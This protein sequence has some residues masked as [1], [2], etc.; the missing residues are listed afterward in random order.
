MPRTA[1]NPTTKFVEQAQ[2]QSLQ[3]IKQSQQAVL[4]AVRVWASALEKAVPETPAIPFVKEL[5]TPLEIV[6]SSFDFAEQLLKAQ[7]EFTENLLDATASVFKPKP[8]EQPE[9]S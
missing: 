2:E 4:E 1:T 6:E 8:A 7:R 9:Q 3:A 5:P